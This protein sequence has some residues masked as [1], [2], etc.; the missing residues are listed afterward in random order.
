[1]FH[2]WPRLKLEVIPWPVTHTASGVD[3]PH[4]TRYEGFPEMLADHTRLIDDA[5]PGTICPNP[6]C[7][8][9]AIRCTANYE[10]TTYYS[11]MACLWSE[12]WWNEGRDEGMDW[13]QLTD[14]LL[15]EDIL[16]GRPTYL[17]PLEDHIYPEDWDP[18]SML[19]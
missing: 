4:K 13:D 15:V 6:G 5:P 1:M 3:V 16:D 11:C 18:G 2:T 12:W 8:F 10:P 19:R 17:G 9:K 7:T 14:R